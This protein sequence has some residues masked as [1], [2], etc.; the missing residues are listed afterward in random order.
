MG[1]GSGRVALKIAPMLVLGLLLVACGFQP[2]MATPTNQPAVDEQ[3]AQVTIDEIPDRVGQE[4]RNRLIDHF[5]HDGRPAKPL[6]RLVIKLDTSQMTLAVQS[7]VSASRSEWIV[8]A[9]YQL[10]YIPNNTL[11]LSGSSRAVPGYNVTYAQYSSFVSENAAFDRG[12]VYVG[13]DIATRVGMYFA[14]DPDQRRKLPPP[15]WASSLPPAPAAVPTVP[16]VVHP[17][18]TPANTPNW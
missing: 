8:T 10:Y 17:S 4:L 12:I 6:Y 16:S 13:D 1:G 5:Y 15:T 2:M 18:S 9:N 7:D 14:R 11:V 3:L